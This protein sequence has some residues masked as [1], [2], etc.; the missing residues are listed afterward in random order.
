MIS[1][2]APVFENIPD[3][4]EREKV[5]GEFEEAIRSSLR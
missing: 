5:A 3:P 1:F 2:I 4:E